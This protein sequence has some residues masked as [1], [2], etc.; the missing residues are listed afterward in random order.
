VAVEAR[1]AAAADDLFARYRATEGSDRAAWAQRARLLAAIAQLDDAR[2]VA[3]LDAEY[4][5]LASRPD[6]PRLAEALAPERTEVGSAPRRA[7]PPE[8]PA[9][10]AIR[11]AGPIAEAIVRG[12]TK[13]VTIR[14]LT[15]E[16]QIIQAGR[17]HFDALWAR[18]ACFASLGALAIGHHAPVRDSL[19]VLLALARRDGL[20]PRRVGRG[21][22]AWG[23]VKAGLGLAGPAQGPFDTAEY[24]SGLG[25][26]VID[27]NALVVWLVAEYVAASGDTAFAARRWGTLERAIGWLEA[28]MLDGLIVQGPYEDWKDLTKRTGRVLYTNVLGYRALD[29]MAGLASR[30]GDREGERRYAERADALARRIDAAFW[31]EAR[32]YYRDTDTW[33]AF[34]A[35]GNF[36]AIDAGLAGAARA[37]RILDLADARLRKPWGWYA[38]VDR[39]YPDR[40]VPAYLALFGMKGYGDDT[41]DM[42]LVTSLYATAAARAGQPA[43]AERALAAVARTTL[44]DGTFEEVYETDAPTPVRRRFYRSEADFPGSA[45]MF[46]HARAALAATSAPGGPTP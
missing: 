1:A 4:R 35:D 8:V 43:R 2:A 30:L 15:G 14:A 21:H 22:N 32:G 36:L 45:G 25:R 40:M 6:A 24:K 16:R 46:L 7:L 38:G 39:P 26:Q 3:F 5:A 10:D 34:S 44:A 41:M 27:T 23:I 37:V 9:A 28:R 20:L 31:D 17:N 33:D 18:D 19:D 11:R 29:A 42:S 13:A 12:N